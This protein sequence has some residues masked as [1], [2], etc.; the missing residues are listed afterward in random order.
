M[1]VGRSSD[2]TV[3][4]VFNFTLY[5]LNYYAV[6]NNQLNVYQFEFDCYYLFIYFYIIYCFY[7]D[8]SSVNCH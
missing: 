5:Y 1:R 8:Y 3:W 6:I 7:L 4:I 2:I